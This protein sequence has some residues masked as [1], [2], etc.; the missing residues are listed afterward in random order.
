MPLN[1][2]LLIH[3]C[4]QVT[5]SKNEVPF[6]SLPEF[7]NWRS[8]TENPHTWKV[9]YYKGLGTSTAKE[10]K[11]YFSDMDR[12]RI[13]FKYAGPEDDEAIVLVTTIFSIFMPCTHLQNSVIAWPNVMRCCPFSDII[14]A[15]ATLI[16]KSGLSNYHRVSTG[17]KGS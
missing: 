9:K 12:H 10:A 7:E 1:Y 3:V 6:Y 8:T 17:I 14:M 4:I 13:P 5:K 2:L 11:E 15:G 16:K